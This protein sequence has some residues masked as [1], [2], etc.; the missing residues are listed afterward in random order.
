M[1]TPEKKL[2]YSIINRKISQIK[3]ICKKYTNEEIEEAA[4]KILSMNT[5]EVKHFTAILESKEAKKEIILIH[6][7][8]RGENYYKL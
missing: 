8:I 5:L 4:K 6:E 2:H 3:F 1:N 7:N